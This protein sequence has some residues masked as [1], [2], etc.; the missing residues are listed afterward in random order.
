MLLVIDGDDAYVVTITL[1]QIEEDVTNAQEP[2]VMPWVAPN[3][4]PGGSTGDVF[5]AGPAPDGVSQSEYLDYLCQL[6]IDGPNDFDAYEE[7]GL[8]GVSFDLDPFPGN[9]NEFYVNF[10]VTNRQG[11]NGVAFQFPGRSV[12][13]QL[14]PTG[15]AGVI[16]PGTLTFGNKNQPFA[17]GQLYRGNVR[18]DM[19]V[20]P[21]DI[22]KARFTTTGGPPYSDPF[23]GRFT[24]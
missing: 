18:L 6:G 15:F 20:T 9:A 4:D 23:A 22:L 2:S 12:T 1:V 3:C 5:L 17:E 24:P 14:P 21:N 19:P 10:E 13:A 16:S 8:V 11:V 7:L